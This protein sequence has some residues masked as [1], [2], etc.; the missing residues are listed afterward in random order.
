MLSVANSSMMASYLLGLLVL[1]LGH[2]YS[3]D[4]SSLICSENCPF[5]RIRFLKSSD[6]Y[7]L[8]VDQKRVEDVGLMCELLGL[9]VKECFSCSHHGEEWQRI[10][11]NYCDLEKHLKATNFPV[12]LLKRSGRK[13]LLRLSDSSAISNEPSK[14][15]QT[16]ENKQ[17]NN[18]CMESDHI[19]LAIPGMFLLCFSLICPCFR[20][21]RKDISEDPVLARDGNAMHSF[22]LRSSSDRMPGTPLRVPASPSRFSLSPQPS[23][24]GPLQLSI[25]QIIKITHNFSPGLVIGEGV[26]RT[27]YKAELPHGGPIVAIK[28]T[29]KEHLATLRAEFSNE[30]ALLTKIEHR[31]LVQ[32]LGY[33]N[34]QNESI[35]ITEYVPHGNLRDHLD[36]QR[37]RILDFSQ[38]LGIAIDVA[39]GLTYLHLYAEKPII[40]RDVKSSNILL[41]ESFRAKVADFGF[42]RTGP[43]EA[44]QTHIETNVKG[45]AGYVDPE[46]LRTYHLTIKS[47]V[48]SFGILLIEILSARRPVELKRHPD[49]KITVRWA[50][51][52]YNE[53]KVRD[54]L[55]P[56][57]QEVV[58]EDVLNKIFSLAF[59][60]A[61]PTRSDRPVM[62][63]V[64]ERLWEVRKDYV[65]NH[66]RA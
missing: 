37:G 64:V 49:E 33:V 54:I 18:S 12:D 53:G 46:Y 42:A 36:G 17:E 32:L 34:T 15:N 14:R 7:D 45:T 65:R 48:F 60:C 59:Q 40:H 22:E 63:E 24:I 57:L 56:M 31:N 19:V 13:L 35:I 61:A 20:S 58:H 26:F 66:R 38:R 27:V 8:F 41:T 25:S 21:R 9:Y 1:S 52:K 10:E 3:V 62:K 5:D 2:G 51:A 55:D 47:D 11:E 4:G 16:K 43:M 29:K 39:H 6:G 30:V 44:D 28:R 50:F 23:T